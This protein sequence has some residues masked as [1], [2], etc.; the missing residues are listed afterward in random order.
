MDAPFKG[1]QRE[2]SHPGCGRPHSAKGW[3]AAHYLRKI[4]GDD[5]DAPLGEPKACSHPGCK[6]PH[7]AKGY[8]SAHYH[9]KFVLHS[10]MDAPIRERRRKGEP[11]A[12]CAWT[13]C[14]KLRGFSSGLCAR[15]ERRRKDGRPMDGPAY[16][17]EAEG[18]ITKQGY[19][20]LRRNGKAVFEHRLVMEAMLSRPLFRQEEVHHKNGIKSDNSPENLELWVS[21]KGQRV[22]DLVSFVVAHYQDR[23]LTAIAA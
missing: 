4:R 22:D 10:D 5:M 21:W 18:W 7:S 1:S 23:L 17:R 6:R 13:R 3:C 11:P 8:C 19:R 9:R 15:H 20:K 12:A 2:C 16:Y 14:S